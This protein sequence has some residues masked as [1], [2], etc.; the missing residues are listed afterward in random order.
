MSLYILRTCRRMQ[1]EDRA[2]SCRSR[3]RISRVSP[4]LNVNQTC[5]LRICGTWTLEVDMLCDFWLFIRRDPSSMDPS[6]PAGETC[7]LRDLQLWECGRI[8]RYVSV[9]LQTQSVNPRNRPPLQTH[10]ANTYIP[11]HSSS[12]PVPVCRVAISRS[13][14]YF[15]R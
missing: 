4:V 11:Q 15:S 9:Y 8:A 1:S 7:V 10:L 3:N 13:R 6:K 12:L 14:N 2:S 5:P